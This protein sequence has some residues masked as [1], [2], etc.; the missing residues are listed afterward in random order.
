ME[1]HSL[2]P[3]TGSYVYFPQNI[4]I[5][6][7]AHP[8]SY[9]K[10]PRSHFPGVKREGMNL[11]IH[12]NVLL[13]LRTHCLHLH[14]TEKSCGNIENSLLAENTNL[15][16]SLKLHISAINIRLNMK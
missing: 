1:D 10:C 9:S 12:I 4:Q 8:A 15:T 14:G 3:D 5:S 6:Y 2:I 13:S 11:T 7:G 16:R